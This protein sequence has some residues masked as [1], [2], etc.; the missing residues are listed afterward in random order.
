MENLLS[1]LP[2]LACP[3][4]MGLM[5][6]CMARTN[7]REEARTDPAATEPILATVAV[8][9]DDRLAVLRAQLEEVQAQQA[10]IT[11]RPEL[12]SAESEPNVSAVLNRTAPATRLNRRPGGHS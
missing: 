10:A 3:I 5:M 8:V 6:W 4:G 2:L 1:V 9:S 12:L 7:S 11:A